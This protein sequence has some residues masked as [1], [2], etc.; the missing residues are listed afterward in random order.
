ML[1]LT[2]SDTQ[3]GTFFYLR[4]A[5]KISGKDFDWSTMLGHISTPTPLTVAR[6]TAN[7]DWL[8]LG[9]MISCC[10]GARAKYCDWHL[11]PKPQILA[12]AFWAERSPSPTIREA[13]G[14]MGQGVGGAGQNPRPYVHT[15]GKS[16][17]GWE[18]GG[19][20]PCEQSP[21]SGMHRDSYPRLFCVQGEGGTVTPPCS[22]CAAGQAVLVPQASLP[23]RQSTHCKHLHRA[24]G[25]RPPGVSCC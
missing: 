2:S 6:R 19:S 23:C 20:E 21:I 5:R 18:Q 15:R 22:P 1:F 14:S 4:E 10:Q 25:G 13:C 8:E 9:H 3:R 24:A 17:I 7:R 16:K 12:G 11:P